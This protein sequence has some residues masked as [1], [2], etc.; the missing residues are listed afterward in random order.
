VTHP[1]SS[2][3]PHM[4]HCILDLQGS[5]A[6]KRKAIIFL[7]ADYR[8]SYKAWFFRILP[9]GARVRGRSKA[10]LL[11]VPT[12]SQRRIW[13]ISELLFL[14][15]W[16]LRTLVQPPQPPALWSSNLHQSTLWLRSEQEFWI[17]R[18]LFFVFNLFRHVHFGDKKTFPKS[19]SVFQHTS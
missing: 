6:Q 17:I 16:R 3:R 7:V 1:S 11:L 10:L 14:F 19:A 4:R 8:C 15:L 2:L 9:R 13:Q 18:G 12:N 5:F